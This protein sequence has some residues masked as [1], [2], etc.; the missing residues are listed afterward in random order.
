MF[1]LLFLVNCV[2]WK[3][4]IFVS[5]W[6]WFIHVVKVSIFFFIMILIQEEVAPKWYN[7]CSRRWAMYRE[8]KKRFQGIGICWRYLWLQILKDWR[9]YY[10][11]GKRDR[12]KM[13]QSLKV[14][15]INEL[16]NACCK[17]YRVIVERNFTMIL[18][19][20]TNDINFTETT[21]QT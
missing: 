5:E 7:L 20:S 6:N 8:K 13:F 15:V 11:A 10:V 4:K 9:L 3:K 1:N 16:A 18:R 2:L 21:K 14:I 12:G 19:L 17:L